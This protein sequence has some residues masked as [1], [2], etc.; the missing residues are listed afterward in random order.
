MKDDI[1]G[2]ALRIDLPSLS[3]VVIRPDEE[4]QDSGRMHF[5]FCSVSVQQSSKVIQKFPLWFIIFRVEIE[6]VLFRT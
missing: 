3:T 4:H 2:K 6:N 1:R 5:L